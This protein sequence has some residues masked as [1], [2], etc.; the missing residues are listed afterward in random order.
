MRKDKRRGLP[1]KNAR[2]VVLAACRGASPGEADDVMP[3]MAEAF[4]PVGVPTV[5][6]SSYDVDDTDAPATMIRLHTYLRGGDDAAD[7]LEE[8]GNR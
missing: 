8:N 1:L 3:T 5:I 7:A 4:A 6:A 2:V